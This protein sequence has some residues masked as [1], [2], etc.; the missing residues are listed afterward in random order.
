MVTAACRVPRLPNSVEAVDIWQA[1]LE[2][3]KRLAKERTV[4]AHTS[5]GKFPK[6]Q[7]GQARDKAA[8]GTGRSG[9]TLDKARAIIKAAEDDRAW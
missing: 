2:E 6:Q 4:E 1:V 3:E 5:P 8:R 9:R 7:Q